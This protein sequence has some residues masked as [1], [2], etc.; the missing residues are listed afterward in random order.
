M[1]FL[2]SPTAE[3]L[4]ILPSSFQIS[5]LV[6]N[7]LQLVIKLS[8]RPTPTPLDLFTISLSPN[9]HPIPS[10]NALPVRPLLSLRRRLLHPN[11]PRTSLL[12]CIVLVMLTLL[13]GS[14][15]YTSITVF[16]LVL[17]VVLVGCCAAAKWEERREGG[18]GVRGSMELGL[19]EREGGK[20][21]GGGKLVG[22]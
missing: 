1:L 8:R 21:D 4:S 17:V 14:M 20:G 3:P 2:R 7:S 19:G 6:K 10:S 5:Q 12:P 16:D 15:G 22:Y 9:H 18:E 13:V 11:R